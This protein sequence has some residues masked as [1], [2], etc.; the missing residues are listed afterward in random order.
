MRQKPKE[1]PVIAKG[2]RCIPCSFTIYLFIYLF[3]CGLFN[4]AVCNYIASND[5][6]INEQWTGKDME[7]SDRDLIEVTIPAFAWRDW[8]KPQKFSVRVA[9]L[10]AEIWTRYL[11]NWKWDA[12]RCVAMFGVN[13]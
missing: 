3:F 8:G 9:S 6:I 4:D 5:R 13:Y 10:R 12:N 2:R 11:Q 1:D 7:G